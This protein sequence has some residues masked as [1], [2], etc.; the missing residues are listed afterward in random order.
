MLIGMIWKYSSL[1]DSFDLRQALSEGQ[2]KHVV[3]RPV[4]KTEGEDR[5]SMAFLYSPRPPPPPPPPPQV[6]SSTHERGGDVISMSQ[7]VVAALVLTLVYQLLVY[8]YK[9]F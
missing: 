6:G 3:G 8:I 9:N 7:Q 5:I 2:Y 4:Y 1:S